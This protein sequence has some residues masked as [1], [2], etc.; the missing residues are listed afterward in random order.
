MPTMSANRERPHRIKLR[1]V[2]WLCNEVAPPLLLFTN[3][4][5]KQSWWPLAA[6][7]ED[8]W[9]QWRDYTLGGFSIVQRTKFWTFVSCTKFW[10]FVWC[11]QKFKHLSH[12]HKK[13]NIR[14]NI[15]VVSVRIFEICLCSATLS[16]SNPQP[17]SQCQGV[18][19]LRIDDTRFSM[20]I[21]CFSSAMSKKV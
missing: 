6:L 4:C 16:G 7:Y 8:R 19:L 17:I 15:W 21:F 14:V 11:T 9:Q 20:L 13:I 2:I 5:N 18:K 10:T 3:S 1:M 12:T